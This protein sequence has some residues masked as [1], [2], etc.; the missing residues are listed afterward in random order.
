MPDGECLVIR[1]DDRED[2]I[3]ERLRAY[4]E[5]TRPILAH[6]ADYHHIHG[7]RSPAYIFE[8]LTGILEPL[9]H[10]NGSAPTGLSESLLACWREG[11]AFCIEHRWPV[12]QRAIR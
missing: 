9:F 8:E 3:S 4:D 1:K 5:L 2:V 12:L 6:Y 11:A 7:D 10:A